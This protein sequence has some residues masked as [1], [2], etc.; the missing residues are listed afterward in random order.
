MYLFP[1]A[2]GPGKRAREGQRIGLLLVMCVLLAP[3][4]ALAH[5]HAVSLPSKSG[6]PSPVP[7]SPES[8]SHGTA[9]LDCHLCMSGAWVTPVATPALQVP[10]ASAHLETLPQPTPRSQTPAQS[11]PS[12]APPHV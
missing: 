7:G 11:T 4:H 2:C 6:Q 3:L 5:F 8:G 10:A 12:R 1:A 9:R